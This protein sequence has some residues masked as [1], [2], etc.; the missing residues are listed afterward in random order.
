MIPFLYTQDNPP[1]GVDVEMPYRAVFY[2]N[3]PLILSRESRLSRARR[4]VR[5]HVLRE[6]PP[7]ERTFLLEPTRL[8]PSNIPFPGGTLYMTKGTPT[9]KTV[10]D[11]LKEDN[12]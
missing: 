9:S 8:S 4:W 12:A 2:A 7:Q 1:E 5:R 6:T 10:G 11:L 3:R